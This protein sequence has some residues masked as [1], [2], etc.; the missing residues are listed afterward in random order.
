[1]GEFQKQK[2]IRRKNAKKIAKTTGKWSGY[3]IGAGVALVL[4]VVIVLGFWRWVT[5]TVCPWFGN[6]QGTM[7]GICV[8][9]SFIYGL[10]QAGRS[11]YM[12]VD[13]G[14][15][16]F[17][18]PVIISGIIVGLCLLLAI[19]VFNAQWTSGTAVGLV[20]SVI[21]SVICVITGFTES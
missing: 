12:W 15:G 1:M 16:V 4:I 6:N 8:F 21:A 13:I 18:V 10:I 17:L 14:G 3:L 2:E 11:T 20:I 5:D 9:L 7:I 19:F